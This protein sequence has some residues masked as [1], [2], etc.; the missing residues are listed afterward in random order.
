[1]LISNFKPNLV[2]NVHERPHRCTF[3]IT[4]QKKKPNEDYGDI[5]ASLMNRRE[6]NLSLFLSSELWAKE[7]P[8]MADL[9]TLILGCIP[10][11]KKSTKI[12]LI[13]IP[14]SDL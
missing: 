2:D 8:K 11:V 5:M 4:L 1:M 12:K 3:G 9:I 14:E 10:F 13:F 7:V 6:W